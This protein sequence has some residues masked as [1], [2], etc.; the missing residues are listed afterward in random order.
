MEAV[1]HSEN[2]SMLQCVQ[3]HCTTKAINHR[4]DITIAFA[5]RFA[6][7]N[8]IKG[9]L[10]ERT[11]AYATDLGLEPLLRR[12]LLCTDKAGIAIAFDLLLKL[13][14]VVAWR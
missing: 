13:G 12:F 7:D 1:R 14:T 8:Q 3:L 11:L 5:I 10:R 9:V 2:I 4:E 6:Q